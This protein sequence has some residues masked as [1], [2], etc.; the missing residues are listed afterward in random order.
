MD[1]V[2]TERAATDLA[3]RLPDHAE[4]RRLSHSTGE[5]F[6]H[7]RWARRHPEVVI[8]AVETWLDEVKVERMTHD[9]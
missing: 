7:I 6:D 2:I 5:A 4:H 3:N 9:E 1:S 8:D